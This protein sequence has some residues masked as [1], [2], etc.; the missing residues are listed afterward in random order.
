MPY[1]TNEIQ[2]DGFGAQYQKILMSFMASKV[3]NLTFHYRPFG[4]MEHNYNQD[5]DYIEK[6]EN[7][8][9]LKKN[10]PNIR[11]DISYAPMSFGDNALLFEANME[12]LCKSEH[13]DF[14]KQ[15]FWENKEKDF[16][17]N[18]KLNVAVHVRRPNKNDNRTNGTDT[19]D[20]Y[21]LDLIN[22]IKLKYHNKSILFH[23]YS[24]GDKNKFKTYESDDTSIHLN[25]D[26]ENT[27]TG[28]VAADILVT[29]ASSFSYVAA[30]I[31]A[32]EIWYKNFWHPPHKD[33]IV[34]N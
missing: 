6:K 19:P 28:M 33:W 8:I 14:I 7:L 10:I 22:K 2:T 26:I 4:V 32:G 30:F 23:I 17:K 25:E 29:S 34:C 13:M 1:A 3:K 24:Q 31:S 21:Y 5:H 27:F 12:N 15:C 11:P 18:G 20:N 9:N 16:F